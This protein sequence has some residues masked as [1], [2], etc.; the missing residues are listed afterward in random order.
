MFVESGI[1]DAN[2]LVYAIN[3]DAPQYT[4][5]RLLLQSALEPSVKLYVTSQILCEFYSLITNPK[6]VAFASSSADTL[7]VIF[8]LLDLPGIHILP[9]PAH[10][11]TGLMKLVHVT[12]SQAVVCSTCKSSQ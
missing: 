11:V 5:A 12:P 9:A 6:R 1:V 2:I 3:V 4:A 8:D 10:T 7:Q